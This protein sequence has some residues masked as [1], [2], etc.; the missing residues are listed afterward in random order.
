M[1][2]WT[3]GLLRGAVTFLGHVGRKDNNAT[4]DVSAVEG[5]GTSAS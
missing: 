5:E 3:G 1:K 2:T 4:A